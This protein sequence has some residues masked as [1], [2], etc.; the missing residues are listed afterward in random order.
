[1]ALCNTSYLPKRQHQT[2]SHKNIYPHDININT[3]LS[4]TPISLRASPKK[5]FISQG[6]KACINNTQS[7]TITLVKVNIIISIP[8]ITVVSEIT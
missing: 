7:I 6:T 2:T 1:M 5:C 4:I 3:N 8:H